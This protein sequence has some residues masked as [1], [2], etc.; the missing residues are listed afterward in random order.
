[1]NSPPGATGVGVGPVTVVDVAATVDATTSLAVSAAFL[2]GRTNGCNTTPDRKWPST[3][4]EFLVARTEPRPFS[5]AAA[6]KQR[7]GGVALRDAVLEQ[8]AYDGDRRLDP[9]GDVEEDGPP[10][11]RGRCSEASPPASVETTA[12]RSICAAPTAYPAAGGG[13]RLPIDCW[14][15]VAAWCRPAGPPAGWRPSCR[16]RLRRCAACHRPLGRPP[17]RRPWPRYRELVARAQRSKSST[18][19]TRLPVG[20]GDRGVVSPWLGRSR[21]SP[22]PSPTAEPQP[23]STHY[24]LVSRRHCLHPMGLR[25]LRNS[26]GAAARRQSANASA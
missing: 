24:L 14:S 8:L 20:R 26:C 11:R 15:V 18:P 12:P 2:D 21:P 1:M 17:H 9:G 10:R 6:N 3:G 13:G 16:C 7:S 4:D 25:L 22:G 23:V 19:K 5:S